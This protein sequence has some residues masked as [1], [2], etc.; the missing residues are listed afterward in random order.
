MLSVSKHPTERALTVVGAAYSLSG[1]P[2]GMRK[3]FPYPLAE[4]C[5]EGQEPVR[6]DYSALPRNA[7]VT[8][9][10]LADGSSAADPYS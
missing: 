4:V 8:R 7:E 1:P 9:V 2:R 3:L 6:T 10:E 5:S